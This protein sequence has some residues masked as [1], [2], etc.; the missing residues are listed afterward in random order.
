MLVVLSSNFKGLLVLAARVVIAGD[1][2]VLVM[3][4]IVATRAAI[5]LDYFAV[6]AQGLLIIVEHFGGRVIGLKF[7]HHNFDAKKRAGDIHIG[8]VV[9]VSVASCGSRARIHGQTQ[10]LCIGAACVHADG[11]KGTANVDVFGLV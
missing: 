9:I 11:A 10:I 4:M 5:A 3:V 6:L 2:G 8:V 7:L 1:W